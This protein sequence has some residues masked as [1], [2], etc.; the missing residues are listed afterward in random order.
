MQ[1]NDLFTGSGGSLPTKNETPGAGGTE[2]LN[3][4][5]NETDFKAQRHLAHRVI[6]ALEPALRVLWDAS[7]GALCMAVFIISM[8]ELVEVLL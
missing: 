7:M 8:Q 4:R 1:I 6:T 3:Q 2:G 5:T